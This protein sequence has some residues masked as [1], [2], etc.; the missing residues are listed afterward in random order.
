MGRWDD[1]TIVPKWTL[2]RGIRVDWIEVDESGKEIIQSR[3]FDE[4]NQEV[5]CFIVEEVGGIEGFRRGILPIIEQELGARLRFS[6]IGVELVRSSGLWIYRKPEEF[7]G[8]PAHVVICPSQIAN[9][10]RSQFKN[11]ARTLTKSAV[12]QPV[13]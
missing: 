5:S 11:K 1:E 2:A 4:S 7:F 9:V 12:L 13:L 8:N 10:T 3:A 6:T